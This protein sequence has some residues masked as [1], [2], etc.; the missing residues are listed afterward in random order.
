[1]VGATNYHIHWNK[2]GIKLKDGL[3][4]TPS[5]LVMVSDGKPVYGFRIKPKAI[6]KEQREFEIKEILR[7]ADEFNSYGISKLYRHKFVK[8]K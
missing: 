4:K 8:K 3:H 2:M 1:M 7:Q 6:S 5:G